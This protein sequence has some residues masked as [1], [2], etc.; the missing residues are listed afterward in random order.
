LFEWLGFAAVEVAAALLEVNKE[1]EEAVE[2]NRNQQFL[3]IFSWEWLR[4]MGF[5]SLALPKLEAK[6]ARLRN[7]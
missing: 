2:R 6:E 5:S 3:D 1:I 7:K 4:G